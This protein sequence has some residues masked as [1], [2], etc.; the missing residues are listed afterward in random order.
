MFTSAPLAQ[1][2]KD[3]P[4][5]PQTICPGEQDPCWPP[6]GLEDGTGA[7]AGEVLEV[8]VGGVALAGPEDDDAGV[9]TADEDPA[10]EA[11]TAVLEAIA[12]VLEVE[13]LEDGVEEDPEDPL[14]EEALPDEDEEEFDDP[15]PRNEAVPEQV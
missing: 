11:G 6:A 12:E 2:E 15:E 4:S 5:A 7:A 8:P 9:G 3:F 1:S 14:P 13:L 10:A